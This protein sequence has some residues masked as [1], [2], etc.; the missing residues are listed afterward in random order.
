MREPT[1]FNGAQWGAT[2]DDDG[3]PWFQNGALG[4]PAYFQFPIVYGNFDVPDQ[5]RARTST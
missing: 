3:K 2:Q 4:V 5:L 1:G